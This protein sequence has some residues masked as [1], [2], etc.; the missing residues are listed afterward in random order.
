M[1]RVGTAGI[2]SSTIKA[3][4]VAGIERV[5]ELGLNAM[6]LEFVHGI[7]MKPELAREVAKVARKNDIALT[8]HAPFYINLNSLEKPKI[9]ASIARIIKSAKIG[10]LAGAKSV[11]FHAAYYMKK[12]PKEVYQTV[13]VALEKMVAELKQNKLKIK[14]SPET[15]GKHTAFG[16]LDELLSL[17]SEIKQVG[18][19]IDFAHL[20]A[21][22]MGKLNTNKEFDAILTKV[23]KVLGKKVLKDMHMHVSGIAYSDKGERNHLML[24]DSDFKIKALV[25]SLKD[26][27][28]GG[29]LICE[30]P[31]PQVDALYIQSLF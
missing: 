5:A 20:H 9:H 10:E 7:Y 29:F 17:A 19:C 13:K 21:R 12:D 25:K 16:N 2:P 22:T 8:L 14:L 3:G 24:K 6:E 18:L 11:T 15:T 4:T 30:S 31:D 1:L 26:F 28:V 27:K 23:E